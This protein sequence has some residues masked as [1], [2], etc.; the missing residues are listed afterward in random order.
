MS[1]AVR[2]P[3]RSFASAA[4][5]VVTTLED[6]PTA[7]VGSDSGLDARSELPEMLMRQD[8]ADAQPSRLGERVTEIEAAT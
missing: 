4:E 2:P 1:L 6:D 5:S 3:P 8:Q 7:G